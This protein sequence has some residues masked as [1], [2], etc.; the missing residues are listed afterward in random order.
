MA[1]KPQ[2]TAILLADGSKLEMDS[3]AILEHTAPDPDGGVGAYLLTFNGMVGYAADHPDRARVDAL[4]DQ[5]I[6]YELDVR[7]RRRRPDRGREHRLQDR[8]SDPRVT[9]AS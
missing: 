7:A 3:S 2:V 4:A 9:L 1:T 8:S 5:E 6:E